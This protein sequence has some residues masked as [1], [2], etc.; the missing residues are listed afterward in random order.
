MAVTF[1]WLCTRVIPLALLPGT[2]LGQEPAVI[3]GRVTDESARPL[4]AATIAIPALGLGATTRANGE[5]TILVPGARVQGQAATLTARGIGYKPRSV[6]VTLREGTISQ[7]FTLEI[8]PLQLGELVVTGAGTVTEVEKL[9]T[10][11]NYV[12]SAQIVN[13]SEQN[14]VSALAAKAPNVEVVSSSGDPGASTFIQVRGITT[15]GT[16]GGEGQPLFVIDGVPVDNNTDYNNP[17]QQALNG[18]TIF[19]PNNLININPNDI[20]NVEI[21]KGAASGAIYGSRAGQGVVLI[22]TKKGQP[23]QTR[24]SV[25]TSWSIDEHTQLP[26]LQQEYGHGSGGVLSTCTAGPMAPAPDPANLNCF[27]TGTSF[28]PR[29]PAGTPTFDQASGPFQTGYTTDNS[30]SVSGGNDRTTFFLTGAFNRNRGITAGPNNSYQRIS[31][32]FN[33]DHRMTDNLKVGGNVSYVDGSGEFVSTRNTVGGLLLGSWRTTPTFNNEPYLDPIYGLHRSY[34][35]P[36]PGPGSETTTR[37]YNNPL[38]S[39]FENP[40]TTDVGRTIGGISLE[41]TPISWLKINENVGL[42]YQ[43]DERFQAWAQSN[44]EGNPPAGVTGVGGVN[45]GYIKRLTLDHNLTGTLSYRAS[46]NLRGTVTLGQNLNSQQ[47]NSR[48]TLG[49]TLI[50][51]E[52][53]KLGNTAELLLPAYD[54]ESRIRLESYFLQATLDVMDRI[55]LSAAVRNDGASTFGP[56][57]RRNWFPKASAAWVFDRG[58]GGL[59]WLTY[60]K[61]RAAYGESG[62]QPAPYLLGGTFINQAINDGGWGPATTTAFGGKGG[63]ITNFILPTTDLKPERVKELELGVDLGLLEDK[64]DLSVTHYRHRSDDVILQIP[65]APSTGYFNQVANAAALRN[66]GWEVTLN[67]RPYTSTNFSWDVGLQWAR[68]RGV[69]RELAPGLRFYQFPLSGGGNGAGLQVGGVAEVGQPIGAYRGSDYIRCG[70]GLTSEEGVDID[71]TP[72]HCQG[73]PAEA[74]YLG[75][76]GRPQIDVEDTYIL[77]D[78][79]PDWTGSVRTNLRFGK[80]TVGGLLDIRAGGIAFNGTKG[81]LNQ[82]GTSQESADHREG[83]PVRFGRDYYTS[84]E[85]LGTAGIAG[86]G[87]DVPTQLDQSWWQGGASVFSGIDRAFLEPGHFVKLREISVGYTFDQPWITRTLGFNSIEIRV[88]GRNLVSW[89]DYTGVDPETSLLG[90]VTPVRGLNYFNNPQTR[91]FLFSLTLNR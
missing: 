41:W 84:E 88:A 86:P 90:A 64:A 6:Q 49:N 59:D 37:V 87:V 8:N 67:L 16:S 14:L 44:S 3:T 82:F 30:L 58:E 42:D 80:L 20:E 85:V 33:G 65:V 72:G 66:V 2:L 7:D 54:F 13:S 43:N 18:G 10:V 56:D 53:F 5:Y 50:A 31:V 45:A 75:P 62:T 69:T 17:A 83:A 89:N 70:R 26:D 36:N 9:G 73:A 29:I 57:N 55:F 28:G 74:L 22:T 35:F 81:A 78:P 1:R 79:N 15:I 60:G 12:D 21:L 39:A 4:T 24:Y 51:P 76:D 52:P 63:L 46:E 77:G 34:R 48:Q 23:G 91:S 71:N 27:A 38:F 68:N 19:P 25:R 32:R 40:I 47:L 61:L 11:R